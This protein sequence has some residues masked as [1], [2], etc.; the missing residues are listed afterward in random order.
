MR[1]NAF[2]G[3]QALVCV[4]GTAVLFKVGGNLRIVFEQLSTSPGSAFWIH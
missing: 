4:S 2:G 1:A 3:R